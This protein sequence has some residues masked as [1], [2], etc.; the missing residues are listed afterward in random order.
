MHTN[1]I[2]ISGYENTIEE[3]KSYFLNRKEFPSM[4]PKSSL[5]LLM[6]DPGNL[7]EHCQLIIIFKYLE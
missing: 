4:Y 7:L 1:N 5:I 6:G 3:L 2:L